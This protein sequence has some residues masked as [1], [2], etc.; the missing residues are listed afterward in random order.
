MTMA[1]TPEDGPLRDLFDT[2]ALRVLRAMENGPLNMR[3]FTFIS[4]HSPKMAKKLRERLEAA[5]LVTVQAEHRISTDLAIRTT[6]RGLRVAETS[7]RIL[8]LVSSEKPP[9]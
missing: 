4:G 2:P 8:R 1:A 6:P 5:G 7:E 3:T 9:E